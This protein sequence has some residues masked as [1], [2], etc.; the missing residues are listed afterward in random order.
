MEELLLEIRKAYALL[1][2]EAD[3]DEDGALPA[4]PLIFNQAML[5]IH[6][7]AYNV[8][9]IVVPEISLCKDASIDFSFRNKANRYELLVNV[10]DN[11]ITCYGYRNPEGGD[12]IKNAVLTDLVEWCKYYMINDK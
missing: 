3:W 1:D 11:D 9:D 2:F 4:D 12:T 6:L 10:K 7:L 8:P 5:F